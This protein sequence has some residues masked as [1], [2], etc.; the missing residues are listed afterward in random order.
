MSIQQFLDEIYN[1]YQTIKKM[2]S[3]ELSYHATDEL[4]NGKDREYIHLSQYMNNV[5]RYEKSSETIARN[6]QMCLDMK[7]IIDFIEDNTLEKDYFLKFYHLSTIFHMISFNDKAVYDVINY[8]V[9]K[10]VELGIS[11]SKQIPVQ[12]ENGKTKFKTVQ[13][14]YINLLPDDVMTSVEM[15][16]EERE[17]FLQ[18]KDDF[19]PGVLNQELYTIFSKKEAEW[20]QIDI[21]RVEECLRHLFFKEQVAGQC[22]R[23]MQK[24]R[25]KCSKK[26]QETLPLKKHIYKTQDTKEY[27]TD[28]EYK[29]LQKRLKEYYNPYTLEVKQEMSYE[30]LLEM[31]HI[32]YRLGYEE[33]DI[34]RFIETNLEESLS[35]PSMIGSFSQY[36]EKL[37]Y[38]YSEEEL[39]DL[40]T[41]LGEMMICSPIEYIEW[42]E[43][44]ESEFKAKQKV[45]VLRSEYELETIRKKL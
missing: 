42:K 8:F 31:A 15:K 20:T 33:V 10:N 22:I 5:I 12:Y 17:Q 37:N 28:K 39:K 26:E 24:R 30:T 38:Y 23:Y 19:L 27:L 34:K 11:D 44:F 3:D 14:Y 29:E 25:E 43:M 2:I 32:L 4:L 7:E 36:Y 18:K 41:I 16:K 21:N 6:K 35:L 40:K 45:L 9:R 1:L 13:E